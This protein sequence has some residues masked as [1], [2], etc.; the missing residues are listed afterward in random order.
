MDPV[1]RWDVKD[2]GTGAQIE[3]WPIPAS[4]GGSLRFTGIRNLAPLIQNSDTMDLDDQM[5]VNFVAAEM[6]ASRNDK[7]ASSKL[8]KAK[9]RRETLQGRVMKSRRNTLNLAGRP[10]DGSSCER[11]PPLVAYV[12]TP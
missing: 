9:A 7:A 1:Q 5:V 12:R 10:M 11:R 3:V 6:M 2:T 8:A 4:N